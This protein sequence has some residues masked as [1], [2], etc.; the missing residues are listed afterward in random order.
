M[1]GVDPANAALWRAFRILPPRTASRMIDPRM[2]DL[3]GM[4]SVSTDGSR[5]HSGPADR[6]LS[7]AVYGARLAD[8][9]RTM[10]GGVRHALLTLC[11]QS[12]VETHYRR[13]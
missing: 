5:A 11:A 6:S 13:C 10:R 7:A 4:F 8:M 3:R 1:A 12:Q 9:V 2:V